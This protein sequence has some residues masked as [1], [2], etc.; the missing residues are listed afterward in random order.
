MASFE[1]SIALASIIYGFGFARLLH[2]VGYIF[3]KDKVFLTLKIIWLYFFLQGITH[4][5][6]LTHNS[7]LEN[8]NFNLFF[9]DA[10]KASLYYFMCDKVCPANAEKIDSW[11]EHFINE[12]SK[13]WL[14]QILLACNIFITTLLGFNFVF[15]E[16]FYEMFFVGI[17]PWTVFSCL[18]YLSKYLKIN[19]YAALLS[20][21]H[22]LFFVFATSQ[23][24]SVGFAG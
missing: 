5:W 1:V 20:F 9:L 22:I 14:V 24:E 2:G 18:G 19:F 8:Y 16:G 15:T 17:F 13:I 11:E 10:L 4:F 12:R 23:E 6:G 3:S 7:E 21:I